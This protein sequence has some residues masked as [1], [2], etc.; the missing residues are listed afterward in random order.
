ML[1]KFHLNRYT[2]FRVIYEINC[3]MDF[4]MKILMIYQ[5]KLYQYKLYK[6]RYMLIQFHLNRLIILQNIKRNWGYFLGRKSHEACKHLLDSLQMGLVWVWVCYYWVLA[7][8]IWASVRRLGW[9]KLHWVNNANAVRA[10]PVALWTF[11]V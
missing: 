9:Y 10:R 7:Y 1:Y 4:R 2:I 11:S 6:I 8:S 5:I 3:Q